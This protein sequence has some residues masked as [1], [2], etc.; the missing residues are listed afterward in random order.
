MPCFV[1][2]EVTQRTHSALGEVCRL[3]QDRNNVA[4]APRNGARGS[5]GAHVARAVAVQLVEGS[6]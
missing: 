5:A 3:P 2:H 1:H 6:F 4:L